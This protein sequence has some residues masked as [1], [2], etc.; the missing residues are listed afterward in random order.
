MFDLIPFLF[1]LTFVLWHVNSRVL[2]ADS[3]AVTD[4]S[5]FQ[6]IKR[7]QSIERRMY[8]ARNK[9]GCLV[10]SEKAPNGKRDDESG[11]CVGCSNFLDNNDSAATLPSSFL[12]GSL[13]N[14][15]NVQIAGIATPGEDLNTA[16]S[17]NSIF[18]ATPIVLNGIGE[19]SSGT[20][21]LAPNANFGGNSEYNL[22]G[23]FN[24]AARCVSLN[25]I[26]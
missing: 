6:S 14:K 13:N 5:I 12:D 24:I 15:N 10:P 22:D 17:E 23:A 8:I 18:D 4:A 9:D 16:S 7:D 19:P 3:M 21:A 26:L 2:P 25:E 20:P 11:A 1:W